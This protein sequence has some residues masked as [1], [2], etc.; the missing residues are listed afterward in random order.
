MVTISSRPFSAAT[1]CW[2]K[3]GARNVRSVCARALNERAKNCRLI[4]CAIV[5]AAQR[6][7]E[8]A[9][10]AVGKQRA[11]GR[12]L[13]NDA[14]RNCFR[15][16]QVRGGLAEIDLTG[17]AHAFDV[18]SIGREIQIGFKN[19]GFRVMPLEFERA[20]NLHELSAESAGGQMIT[21]P[22]QLHGDGRSAATRPARSQTKC[23]PHQC[24]RV[25]SRMI[26]IVFVFKLESGIDQRGR[27]IWQAKSR[28]DI[29]GRSS[30]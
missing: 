24:D 25:N 5:P 8:R 4:L 26:P 16:R 30:K 15:R 19:L 14:E 22:R 21:Q 1:T 28:P 6:R 11:P 3:C 13:R 12:A 20:N 17:R 2:T 18:S 7:I 27:N 23:R 9:V 29:S 10:I